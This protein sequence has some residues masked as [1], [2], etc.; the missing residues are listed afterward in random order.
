MPLSSI[1]ASAAANPRNHGH[2]Y[3]QLKHQHHKPPPPPAHQPGPGSTST[4]T[5]AGDGVNGGGAG[6][7]GTATT[8]SLI[9]NAN[10]SA[11]LRR[12]PTGLPLTFAKVTGPSDPLWWLALAAGA[13]LALL[14][15]LIGAL[16][17]R[18]VVRR[19]TPVPA[20]A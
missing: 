5:H 4:G 16:L 19:R 20:T 10:R 15:L 13:S 14:W 18:A 6:D 1:T 12:V 7:A 17:A 2:H 9:N 8:G 11:D 3:G